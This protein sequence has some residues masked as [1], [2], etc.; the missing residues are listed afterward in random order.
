VRVLIS[1]ARGQVGRALQRTAPDDVALDL[2]GV[3]DL[4]ICDIAAVDRHFAEF[5]PEIVINAA[6]Y[7]AVDKAESDPLA[8]Q[9]LNA[10]AVFNLRQAADVHGAR[11][12][13]IS[14]DF[15]FDGA[16]GS[17][18]AT[19][20]VPA[21]LSVYGATKLAGER[22]AGAKALIVRTS[23]IYGVDG[24]NFVLTMLR[25]MRERDELRVVADQ[26]GTPTSASSIAE[27]IWALAAQRRTGIWHHTDSGV[28]S[29][30][31]F[32]VAI[33]EEAVA[34]GILRRTIP[35]IPIAT[36]EYPT[37]AMRPS[38]SVLDKHD[39]VAALGY[40]APHWRTN[41]RRVLEELAING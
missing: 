21:P 25:L 38:Y 6:A 4:D 10:E 28:A 7:T 41:L 9:R 39:T 29:W 27:G 13:H 26:V 37:P 1:G 24:S 22:A 11:L 3:A 14:T 15:V 36:S 18:Y 2:T 32:A 12:V 17:P 23:W 31:D 40:A 16:A 20:A 35:V 5:V 19:D 30:Y 33:Q 8:A 34:L